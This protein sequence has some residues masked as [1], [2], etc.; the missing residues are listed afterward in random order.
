MKWNITTDVINLIEFAWNYIP[1]YIYILPWN[2]YIPW[3]KLW[4]NVKKQIIIF[5]IQVWPIERWQQNNDERT[6]DERYFTYLVK[7]KQHEKK[8]FVNK[9]A[10]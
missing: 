6:F 7:T 3:W 5:Q 8:L 2:D 4:T 9:A 1:W 10:M